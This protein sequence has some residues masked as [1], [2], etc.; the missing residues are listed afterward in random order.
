MRVS[1]EKLVVAQ[2]VK[3]CPFMERE[4]SLPCSQLTACEGAYLQKLIV[5]QKTR[6]ILTFME[7]EG[8]SPNPQETANHEDY[9]LLRC[10][11]PFIFML[12]FR[13][14]HEDGSRIQQLQMNHVSMLVSIC[15]RS[16]LVIPFSPYQVSQIASSYSGCPSKILQVILISWCVLNA[17]VMYAGCK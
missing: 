6:D 8:S 3:K 11:E 17:S 4:S 7:P 1:V 14:Y 5:A 2:K 13:S 10:E 16:S 15:L 12:R 9:C